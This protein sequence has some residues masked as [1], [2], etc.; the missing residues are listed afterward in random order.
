MDIPC[1]R[2]VFGTNVYYKFS[3]MLVANLVFVLSFSIL[4]ILLITST[5]M[6]TKEGVNLGHQSS[7]C[8]WLDFT[9][10]T[11]VHHQCHASLDHQK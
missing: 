5:A 11:Q 4:F 3:F 6:V 10:Q 8:T 1:Y 9:F 7:T 2:C